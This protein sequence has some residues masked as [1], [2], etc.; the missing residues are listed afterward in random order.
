MKKLFLLFFLAAFAF[1]V[2]AQKKN[3]DYYISSAIQSS[4]LLKDYGNQTQMNSI[5]SLRI[6]A[7]YKPQVTAASTN[8]YAPV[9]G[10]W[11]YDYAITNGINFSQLITVSK[12]LVSKENLQNQFNTISLQN[13]A[14]SVSG[15][16][17]EQ[18]LRKT[19]TAQYIAAYGTWKQ[20]SFNNEVLNLLQKEE[21]ILKKLT[22]NSVYRQTDYLTFLVTVQQQE[23]INN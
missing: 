8:Y 16:I 9:I 2:S 23:L 13:Q 14:L 21:A 1:S 18:D 10:G 3:L 17:T 22:A 11:G 20:Y 7:G 19:I 4:P 5:D 12:T 6:R 15:K